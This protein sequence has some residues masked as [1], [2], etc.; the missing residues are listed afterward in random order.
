MEYCLSL[1]FSQPSPVP[2]ISAFM[3]FSI[4]PPASLAQKTRFLK[5]I[6]HVGEMVFNHLLSHRPLC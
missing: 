1:Y 6:L 2:T 3:P 5:I 4:S